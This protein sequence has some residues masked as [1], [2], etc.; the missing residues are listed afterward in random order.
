MEHQEEGSRGVRQTSRAAGANQTNKRIV[1]I[2]ATLVLDEKQLQESNKKSR[3]VKNSKKNQDLEV[4]SAG[5]LCN[6]VCGFAGGRGC[7][8]LDRAVLRPGTKNC[9]YS[10]LSGRDFMHVSARMNGLTM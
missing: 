10:G 1:R 7:N 9:F 6:R 3:K 8:R 4:A 2:A 5:G